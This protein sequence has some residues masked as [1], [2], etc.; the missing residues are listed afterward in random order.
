MSNN[1]GGL[2]LLQ[3]SW[4][5]RISIDFAAVVGNSESADH[6][7]SGQELRQTLSKKYFCKRSNTVQEFCQFEHL[8]P[9]MRIAG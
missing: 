2:V 8:L 5:I 3:V 9:K 6:R 4:L 7:N 1:P